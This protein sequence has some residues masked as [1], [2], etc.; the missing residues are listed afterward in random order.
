MGRD[1]R[2]PDGS[3]TSSDKKYVDAWQALAKPLT[4]A[5]GLQLVGWDPDF[6]FASADAQHSLS[7]PKW[8]VQ[9]LAAILGA[10]DA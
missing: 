1:S 4:D 5:M 6:L 10:Q 8:F 7:L 9:D 3:Y 2:L